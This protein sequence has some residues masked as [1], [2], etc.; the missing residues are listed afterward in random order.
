MYVGDLERSVTDGQIYDLFE[1]I[2]PVLSVRI[3][4]DIS[5]KSS[6]GYAYVNYDTVDNGTDP[7]C[8]KL[9][10]KDQSVKITEHDG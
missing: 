1:Q 9:E 3:C 5:T 10:C 2:G 7:D 4:R 8:E 6:L